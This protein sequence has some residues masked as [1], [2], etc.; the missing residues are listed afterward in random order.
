[1]KNQLY[2]WL[3][4]VVLSVL[5][6]SIFAAMNPVF[7]YSFLI[8]IAAVVLLLIAVLKILHNKRKS[9]KTFKDWYED[10]PRKTK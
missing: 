3:P 2:I 9:K 7:P 8:W 10:D 5:A 4:L 6:I 1:M